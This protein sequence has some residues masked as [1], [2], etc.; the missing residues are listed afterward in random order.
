[1]KLNFTRLL[2]PALLI[3]SLS[4]FANGDYVLLLK[5]GKYHLPAGQITES[6]D[7]PGNRN[8]YFR[9]IQF[10]EL[11]SQ[12]E[13]EALEALGIKFFDYL[14][15]KA[16]LASIP[17]SIAPNELQKFAI[18]SIA[19]LK[20]PMKLSENLG[21]NE[22]PAWARN[23]DGTVNLQAGFYP[24]LSA[25][26]IES[27]LE[28]L[29]IEFRARPDHVYNVK[30]M[31][32]KISQLTASELVYFLQESDPE[33]Q[34]ETFRARSN[35]R[36]N[37]LQQNFAGGRQY[38]GDGITVA[39]GDDGNL[40]NHI[41]YQGRL[42][43]STS[44]PNG[45]NHGE[46]VAGI[47]FGAGNINPP[48][49]GMAPACEVAYYDY[50]NAGSYY[51][52]GTDTMYSN[53][54]VVITQSSYSNGTNAGYT[55]L[56]R[57][58]DQDVVDNRALM[59]VFSAGNA[60]SANG[61]YG[62]GPGWGNITGGHKQGKNV[63]AT[64]NL[65]WD[66]NLNSSSSRGPA[67]DGR[68]KPDLG[69]VGTSVLTTDENNGYRLGGGT[70]S[71]APGVSGNLANLYQAYKENNAQ[72]LPDAGL[73]KAILMNTAE[74]LGNPGPDFW[75]GYGRINARR[76]VEVVENNTYFSGTLSQGQSDTYN[77]NVGS[78]IA[79]MR[80][81]LYWTDAP[82]SV[83]ASRALVN[84]LDLLVQENNN[85]WQPWV[86]DPTPNA[87]N[88]SANAV[89]ATDSLNNAEQVTLKSPASGNYQLVISG[90]AIPQG[91]QKYFV[92][93]SL[94]KNEV[95]LSQPNGG[96]FF[97]PGEPQIIRWDAPAGTTP[98]HL[99]YSLDN[100]TSWNTIA[101]AVPADQR[102]FTWT[103]PQAVS[104]EALVRITR[105]KQSDQS[106]ANFSI[107]GIPEN[108]RILWACQDSMMIA[109]DSVAGAQQYEV[110]RLGS[111]YMDS[112]AVTTNTYYTFTGINSGTSYWLSV[113]ARGANG[114][115]GERAYAIEK[116]PG[117]IN[118]NFSTDASISDILRPGN[119]L[120]DCQTGNQT[121]KIEVLNAGTQNLFNIP[122]T[123]RYG[124]NAV[125]SDTINDTLAPGMT[126]T[127]AF[128]AGFTPSGTG[129]NS[130]RVVVDYPGDLNPGNDDLIEN[131]SVYTSSLQTLPYSE[132]FD[133][134]SSCPTTRNCEATNCSLVNGWYNAQNLV[135]DDIDLRT[136]AGGTPSI[137]TGPSG[138]HT[139]GS[140]NYLYTETS[141][142]CRFKE[143]HL[144]TP[145]FDLSNASK[146]E[147][148]IWYHMQG[149]SMGELHVDI[150]HNGKW[151]RDVVSPL[152]GDQGGQWQKW[153][154]DLSTFQGQTINLR[155]RAI[156]GS[157]WTS[158]IAVDDFEIRDALTAPQ[159]IF[160]SDR[161]QACLQNT[162][163]LIDQSTENPTSWNWTISPA[164][165][166][167][168][169]GTNANSQ[170]PEVVFN[171]TGTYDVSLSVSNAIGTDQKTRTDLVEIVNE[172]VPPL[173]E[174]FS[175]PLNNINW[176]VANP[177]SNITWTR[178]GMLT[179]SDNNQ[180][181][182]L[183]IDNFNYH[184]FGREDFFQSVPV[185]LKS[186][187]N[188][189]L[190]FDVAHAQY[191]NSLDGLRIDISTDC[192]ESFFPSAYF[193]Q[194]SAL[195]TVNERRSAFNPV[196]SSDW[197]S[198]TLDLS[199]FMGQV[200]VLRFV[201]LSGNGNNL[202]LDNINIKSDVF[203]SLAEADKVD[204]ISL[205]PNPA[206]ELVWFKAYTHALGDVRFSV[207]DASG[208]IKAQATWR[209]AGINNDYRFDVS[210]LPK[211][212]YVVRFESDHSL[213]TKRLIIQ[214]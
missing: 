196:A 42:V 155:F 32:D 105:A 207:I 104:G 199:A 137:G 99:E 63:I 136:N 191:A 2:L 113:K 100:G 84:D 72:A 57:Q 198:D 111:K 115:V 201:A 143:G 132:D 20:A 83:N 87:I 208:K 30:L 82:A 94:V 64:A 38:D 97:A 86:L 189:Y 36:T 179:G 27:F 46:M 150:L 81:M 162:V 124:T 190:V 43:Y 48:A 11:P 140:G 156:S 148:S 34:P 202:F 93:Y 200:I 55:F 1:M 168:V 142:S 23:G 116:T 176:R 106:E 41:D 130:L 92:V 24:S 25:P 212:L 108:L 112:V 79:E 159:S 110:S 98:F 123:F 161:P 187:I 160:S 192:G 120:P 85:S 61:G 114:C 174:D 185:D 170:N 125:V 119:S 15:K 16:Y 203:W 183:F 157:S 152:S 75:F 172:T 126:I 145:C 65:T 69:A 184:F 50:W 73:M 182:A 210:A 88:L 167:F 102:Y 22:I 21:K 165:Y 197:R 45:G 127:H 26:Q 3:S 195:A 89:R 67:H 77:L 4:G 7:G 128:N 164:S 188:P 17:S 80:V 58:M 14:P 95:V 169:N 66:D 19:R 49:R 91:P 153:T 90:N 96:E 101:S 158:D 209:D 47:V 178:T 141:G 39:I 74:D 147:A 134:F 154:I 60:A 109:W 40:F 204:Q 206:S 131:F 37:S 54:D 5:S 214:R 122:V 28:S 6:L 175:S 138:D 135:E 117:T 51:L 139:S 52:D 62:A 166:S 18:R 33:P 70:S 211:G 35:H 181:N 68:I 78:D 118:C 193:K 129:S 13:R 9:I 149:N 163:R 144:I 180:T 121:V 31:P 213:S 44:V 205:M 194:G 76:A 103:V 133:S 53:M 171:A 59:H 12:K 151:L 173:V 56:C 186:S 107:I 177:D 71:A 8:Q 10:Y 29:Q 146:P